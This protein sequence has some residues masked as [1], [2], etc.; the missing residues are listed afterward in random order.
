MNRWMKGKF[1][2]KNPVKYKGN[3]DDITFRSSW[4]LAIMTWFDTEPDILAWGSEEIAIT[5]FDPVQNKRRKYYV[6]F[7]IV[8]RKADGYQVT[9]I[10]VKPY[11]QTI[12][13]RA[14]R[15]KSDKTV[16]T[17]QTTWLTNQAKW[18]AAK[19]FADERGWNFK[20]ITERELFGGI[21]RGFK[22]PKPSK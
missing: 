10:E 6:D 5:Y 20:I 18:R 12:K 7:Q 21:D 14:N 13:P 3:A 11:K 19:A 16:V 2:P 22:P 17:E 15:N 8:T 4:E 9:L 1:K